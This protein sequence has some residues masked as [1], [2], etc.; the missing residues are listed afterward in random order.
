MFYAVTNVTPDHVIML[1]Q[2]MLQTFSQQ[3]YN[4]TFNF[5]DFERSEACIGCT[6]MFILFSRDTL[7][8]T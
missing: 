5:L 2:W 3:P 1:L 6:M 4:Y 8:Y 7:W